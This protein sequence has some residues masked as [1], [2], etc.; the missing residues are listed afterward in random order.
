MKVTLVGH[1]FDFSG[2]DG[3]SRYSHE[4]YTK[5]RDYANKNRR[6]LILEAVSVVN[7]HP[8]RRMFLNLDIEN[9]DIVHLMYPNPIGIAKSEE[10]IITTWHD[11]RVFT[12][13]DTVKFFSRSYYRDR[14]VKRISLE[15]YRK[16]DAIVSVSSKTEKDLKGYLQKHGLFDDRK[17]YFVVNE[18]IDDKFLRQR[19]WKGERKDFGYIGAIHQRHKNLSG[20]LELFN[21]IA[22]EKRRVRLHVFTL[23]PDAESILRREMG[24][25]ANLSSSNVILH[26]RATDEEILEYLPRFVA[27][28]HLS[29][30][31]GFGLPIMESLAVGTRVLILDKSNIPDEVRRYA[32]R[33]GME[34]LVNEAS[35]LIENPSPASAAAVS[36]ARGF[37]W[38]K[39]ALKTVEIYNKMFR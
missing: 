13:S 26:H 2:N 4:V 3:I 39:T 8:I 17:R 21:E 10:R 7:Y 20:L 33:S 23:S 29:K 25:F 37:T 11:N 36:Y 27:Y 38:E 32:F 34:G 14:A 22:E 28:L 24:L 30:M 15:N 5:L 18:G 31:E 19:V 1:D 35:R 9:T 16:S 6:K 12:R